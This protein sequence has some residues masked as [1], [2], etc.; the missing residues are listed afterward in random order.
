MRHWGPGWG[1]RLLVLLGAPLLFGAFCG[2]TTPL[3]AVE[4]TITSVAITGPPILAADTSATYTV[5][6]TATVGPNF[7]ASVN[8]L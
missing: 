2:P 3:V 5:T 1:P 7:T 4:L 6:Y 8:L